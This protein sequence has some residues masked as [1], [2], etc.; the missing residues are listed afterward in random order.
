[1]GKVESRKKANVNI[2]LVV[3]RFEIMKIHM[4]GRFVFKLKNILTTL[5]MTF[6]VPT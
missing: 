4:W 3:L 1:M 5:V 2:S 6:F